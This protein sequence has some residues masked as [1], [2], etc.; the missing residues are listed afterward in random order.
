MRGL[1]LIGYSNGGSR[2]AG[3]DLVSVPRRCW[4]RPTPP[5]R[6]WAASECAWWTTPVTKPAGG[7]A[8][9]AWSTRRKCSPAGPGELDQGPEERA[10]GRPA[11]RPSLQGERPPPL[12]HA[13][14]YWLLDTLRRWLADT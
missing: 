3:P 6:G 14:A 4:P 5:V 11:Q 7:P 13:A 10:P 9:A 2:P 1:L 12:L 8:P